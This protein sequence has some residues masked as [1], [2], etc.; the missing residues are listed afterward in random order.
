VWEV[1]LKLIRLKPMLGWGYGAM[2]L[3]DRNLRLIGWSPASSH[4]AF[5]EI[6]LYTGLLGTA[7]FLIVLGI[8]LWRALRCCLIGDDRL[9]AFSLIFFIPTIL[10]G[11]IEITLAQNQNMEWLLFNVLSFSCGLELAK[12]RATRSAPVNSVAI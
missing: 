6:A 2:W 9:G 10:A 8:A 12:L 11:T 3:G 4:D 5:L 1:V 7:V